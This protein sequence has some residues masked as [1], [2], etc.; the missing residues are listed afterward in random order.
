M[1]VYHDHTSEKKRKYEINSLKF[2]DKINNS[3]NKLW[4]P[5]LYQNDDLVE[6]SSGALPISK[7]C[8]KGVIII[9]EKS[10]N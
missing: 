10:L 3:P 4:R 9:S 1:F 5:K 8:G 2:D 6:Y 7:I